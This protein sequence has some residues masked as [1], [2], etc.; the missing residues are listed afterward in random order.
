MSSVLSKIKE[1][2][3]G[4]QTETYRRYDGQH[5]LDIF[6]GLDGSRRKTLVITLQADK[7]KVVSSKNITV[8]FFSRGDG[9]VSLK[10]SLEN[11]DLSDIFYKFCEDVIESTRSAKPSGG[12]SLAISR[13]NTWIDFFAKEAL[14]LSQNEVMGL[15]G[16]LYFLKN[17]MFKKYGIKESLE[18]FIGT[19][20]A[21][22]DFE[23]D[24]T[25]FEVKAIH[26]G[27]RSVQISSIEQLDSE[28]DGNL[29]VV[30]LDQSTLNSD[31]YITIN[32]IVNEVRG[33]LSDN[34]AADFDEKMRRAKFISNQ[35]YDEFVYRFVNETFYVVNGDFPRVTKK[36]LPPGITKAN[37]EIDISAIERYSL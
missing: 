37:Y 30:T 3:D 18:A 2:L 23:I 17:F 25:W 21:H 33:I 26:N 29:V 10:F 24:D 4:Q 5:P 1:L 35:K 13:W 14:P 8:E 19:N 11:N 15:I 16:E 28:K 32:K 12:F 31:G 6:L 22:K 9:R 34:Q 20:K 27:K 7:E 36:N